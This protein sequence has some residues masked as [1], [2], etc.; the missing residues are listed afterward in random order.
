M[1]EE[2]GRRAW[3]PDWYSSAHLA[4]LEHVGCINLQQLPRFGPLSILSRECVD[5]GGLK[6]DRAK[7]K[8]L[9]VLKFGSKITGFS[10]GD[11]SPHGLGNGL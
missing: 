11:P 4:A 1:G 6:A 10:R 7:L 3:S 9:R 5:K 2:H 8:A